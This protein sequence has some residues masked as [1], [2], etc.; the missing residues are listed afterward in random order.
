MARNSELTY[1][2]PVLIKHVVS[3]AEASSGRVLFDLGNSNLP[4]DD[5]V[6][7]G[8]VFANNI[9]VP[10]FEWSYSSGTG[11]VT[12]KNAGSASLAE[13][14]KVIIVGTYFS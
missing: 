14:N 3:A 12:V 4:T 1:R 8:Q 9:E 5:F 11:V 2:R 10:G 13:S 6:F 7:V